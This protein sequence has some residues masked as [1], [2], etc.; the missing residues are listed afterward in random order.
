VH[1]Q[2]R[3]LERTGMFPTILLF[4]A[5]G[6]ATLAIQHFRFHSST[7]IL[8]GFDTL[9]CIWHKVVMQG[10]ERAK[11]KTLDKVDDYT[12]TRAAFDFANHQLTSL[13]NLQITRNVYS[14]KR[15]KMQCMPCRGSLN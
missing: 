9:K 11:P 5:Q 12:G 3:K 15:C 4:E 6:E 7:H 14:W 10:G 1:E 13:W 8:A 2:Q